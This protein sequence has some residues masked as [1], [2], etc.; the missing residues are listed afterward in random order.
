MGQ[1]LGVTSRVY[2]ESDPSL[3]FH[4]AA[5]REHEMPEWSVRKGMPASH[6]PCQSVD[7]FLDEFG[8]PLGRRVI[9]GDCSE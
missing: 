4:H 2:L 6:F 5:K 9:L 3:C 7:V 1:G 8:R